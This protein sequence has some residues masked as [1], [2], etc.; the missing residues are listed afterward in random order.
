MPAAVNAVLLD[1]DGTIIHDRR[2]LADPDGVE[3]LPDAAKGL[4][5]LA[6]AGIRLFIAS[7]QSGI[8]RGIISR[9]AHEACHARLMELLAVN[10]L[11]LADAVYCPHAPEESCACRKPLTGM[12]KELQ[13]GHALLPEQSAMIGDKGLDILFGKNANLALT[14][15]V[16]TGKGKAEAARMKLPPLPP[17]DSFLFLDAPRPEQPHAVARDLKGAAD[18]VLMKNFPEGQRT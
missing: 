5:L 8:G 4:G 18:A 11:E 7:N 2:Y 1:R 10:R 14:I 6:G 9:E 15:L 17:D 16:L 13:R 3:F 12:W